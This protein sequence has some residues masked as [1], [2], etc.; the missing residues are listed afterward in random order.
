MRSIAERLAE[1]G[2]T[3]HPEKSKIVYCQDSNRTDC[4]PNVL[5]TF[6]GFTF[7]PRKA[8]SK[9]HRLF[10]SF[11]PGVSSDAVKRMR[12]VV[13]GWR[14]PRQTPATLAE[15]AEQY[16]SVIRGWCEYY[17]T[18]Y[19]TA[20]RELF[21]YIDNKLEQWARR[22]Y[23]TLSRHKRRSVE[24]LSRVKKGCPGLFIHWRVFENRVG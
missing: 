18:F 5:F 15:L 20:M 11:L 21:Q 13:R 4:F 22:K 3:M 23:K 24:W 14:I 19:Q 9:Q 10:T 16:N 1:C 12:K 17:G 8:M 2:L 6:L 7:L